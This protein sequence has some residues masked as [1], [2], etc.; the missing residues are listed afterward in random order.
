M[1]VCRIFLF[2]EGGAA[3]PGHQPG[4]PGILFSAGAMRIPAVKSAGS[5]VRIQSVLPPQ[6]GAEQDGGSIGHAA[7]AKGSPPEGFGTDFIDHVP[8]KI[9][10]SYPKEGEK[11]DD[12]APDGDEQARD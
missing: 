1:R 4:F 11:D 5:G 6:N 7:Q 2:S 12:V 10:L 8:V 3:V 9:G